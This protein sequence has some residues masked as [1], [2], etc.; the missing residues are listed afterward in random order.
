MPVYRHPIARSSL[1]SPLSRLPLDRGLVGRLQA[2]FEPVRAS[3]V[4]FGEVFYTRLHA[5]APHLRAM[6]RSDPH[7]QSAKLVASLDAIVRNLANPDENAAML[8]ALGQRHAAYGVRPEH[9]DLVI[10]VLLDSLREILGPLAHEHALDEWRIALR[11]VSDQMIAA[12]QQPPAPGAPA[13]HVTPAPT[14]A[15][16]LP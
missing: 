14:H 10:D 11:L 16:P 2:S 15:R 3:G 13:I 4:R 7:T 9:Y 6:F 8:N 5:A 12:A 1:D